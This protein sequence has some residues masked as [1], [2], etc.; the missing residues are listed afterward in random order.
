[1]EQQQQNM[2]MISELI[3]W[4]FHYDAITPQMIMLKLNCTAD[5]ANAIIIT[6]HTLG[7]L[8]KNDPSNDAE[9]WIV[10][11]NRLQDIPNHM[12]NVLQ[13]DGHSL[14]EITEALKGLPKEKKKISSNI[15]SDRA[16][17]WT[18]VQDKAPEENIPII[19]RIC[20]PEKEFI[21]TKTE[22]VY[23]EDTKIGLWDG[24]KWIICGPHPKYDFSPCSDKENLREGCN[25]THWAKCSGTELKGWKSRL[26]PHHKYDHMYI[27]VDEDKIE[28]LYR[29]LILAC[30]CLAKEAIH[31][32]KDHEV[33]IKLEEAYGYIC[34]FQAAF[35]RNGSI[36]A[37]LA[38]E[39]E[40]NN[41]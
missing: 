15:L 16:H 34:D 20:N 17:E 27:D 26:D 36:N 10:M 7:I 32:P 5:M 6:L 11:I 1:M 4:A 22:I 23:L 28:D 31:Y 41:G 33:R 37:I 18:A 38:T 13:A 2:K 14:E 21:E 9:P 3:V 30:S 8:N 25:V 40:N 35:D 24:N 12:L 29:S 39:L 19:I